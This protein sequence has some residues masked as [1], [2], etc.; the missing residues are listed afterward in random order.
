MFRA[1]YKPRT[2]VKKE[3]YSDSNPYIKKSVRVE[4]ETADIF[5][6]R[7]Y[8]PVTRSAIAFFDAVRRMQTGK[9]NAYL[10]YI[11]I[12]LILLLLVAGLIS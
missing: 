1:L 11:M 9:V 12:T 3:Y 10:L 4:A 8:S 7:L 2:D 5:E 6:N